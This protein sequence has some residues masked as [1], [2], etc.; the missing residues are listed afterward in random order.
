VQLR[1][2]TVYQ[3]G[4]FEVDSSSG[5]LLKNGSR[6]KLQDQPYRLLIALLENPGEV[7][8]REA[9]RN[10]LWQ[11]DTFVD[12]ENGLR[13]AVR[14]LREALGDDAENPRYI[15]TLPKRGYRFLAAEVHRVD[16]PALIAH[17]NG[18]STSTE[19]FAVSSLGIGNNVAPTTKL[20]WSRKWTS[21]LTALLFMVIS[22]A[23]L[24]IFRPRKILTVRDTVVLADFLN[25]T[26]DPVF[27]STLRQGLAVSFHSLHF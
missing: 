21:I 2:G 17:S 9:L 5:E 8:S 13:V 22:A 20:R 12:F 25:F 1:S 14:K 16:T 23:L 26:G 4:P 24:F 15:E 6:V 7:I 3:F 11:D 18:S 19:N 10:R 27:D